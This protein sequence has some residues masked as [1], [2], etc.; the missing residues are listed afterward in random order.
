MKHVFL[1][2]LSSACLLHS[3]DAFAADDAPPVIYP[4]ALFTFTERGDEVEGQ[5][6]KVS[7]LLFAKLITRE[8]IYLVERDELQKILQEQELSTAGIVDPA[9]SNRI[10]QLTGARILLSGSVFQVGDTLYL[11][12][13]IIGTE[14]SRVLGA[15][16]K[17]DADGDLE[18]LV[19][20]LAKDIAE[21]LHES[22]DKLMPKSSQE[23][24]VLARLKKQLKA[25]ELPSVW[26]EVPE[27]HIGAPSVDP[28]VETELTRL[29][30]ELGF[31][32]I[33]HEKGRKENADVLL[34]GEAFSQT[35][36][37]HGNFVVVKSRIEL[38]A[39][40]R[41]SGEVITADQET[42]VAID[43]A[44][45]IAAKTSLQQG[46]AAMALRVLPKIVE[47]QK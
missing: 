42:T 2:L 14:T 1:I 45:M 26:I 24:D 40:D 37:R 6:R 43:L 39:V 35:A 38:K 28:A 7:D 25:E 3:I 8:D 4:V 23:S 16:A 13:K 46:A 11:V 36:T 47:Y 12:A 18:G 44:E 9:S 32:V 30:T 22:A 19:E 29:C 17:G 10:G 33:D 31:V 15:S 34:T 5:G 20:Q 21:K 27:R 41:Q